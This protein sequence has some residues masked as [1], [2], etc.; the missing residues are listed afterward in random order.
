MVDEPTSAMSVLR[1]ALAQSPELGKGIV[2]SILM[3]AAV[4]IGK[5]V[6]P[7]LVQQILDRGIQDDGSWRPVFVF[8][9]GALALLIT[10]ATYALGRAT[11]LRLVRAAEDTLFGLRLAAFD[12]VHRLSVADHNDAK[13][14]LLVS[15]VTSDIETIARFAQWGG[16]AWPINVVLILGV[17]VM[18]GFYSWQLTLVAIAVYL[19]VFPILR[20]LQKRQLAA[21]E[22]FRT[23]VGETISEFSEAI[24]GA[25]VLRAY[26]V[27]GRARRRLRAAVRAQYEAD[28]GAA[29]FFSFVFSVGDVFGGLALAAVLG[30]GV[31]KGP[32]WGLEVGELIAVLFLV[33]LLQMPVSELGEILDTTQ[34]AIAGWRKVLDLIDTPVEI[35]EPENGSALESGPFAVEARSVGFAYRTGPP[36][37]IGVDT[38]I[39]AGANVAIVGQTGSGKTTFA[40][41][42]ARLADPLEGS[43][44]FA[45]V[46]L[47]ELT[48]AARHQAVRMVPQDGFLF[49]TTIA[50]NVRFGRDGATRADVDVA[51]ESLELGWWVDGLPAGLETRVGE[52]GE[53]L[54]VGE[55]QLVALARAQLADPGLLILDEATSAVDPETERALA[56]ALV[57]LAEGRTMVSIAHRL[58][59]AEVADQ[60]LVFDGGR[61][62]EQGPHTELV[63][64]GGIYTKMYASWVGNTRRDPA[65]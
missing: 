26:G 61:L 57:R 4:A 42:L 28:L 43:I 45:A 60:V 24:M 1:R 52:R 17:V 65:A 44:R 15:R 35:L 10:L 62:V 5:L 48:P 11:Y 18:L 16:V 22:V 32:G 23:R 14:G 31:W 55:R 51:F 20:A 21:Y 25:A 59:T 54:S 38:V 63:A 49:D 12:H 47:R 2:A 53:N 27:T 41:L 46:D 8:T 29:K 40:K 30:V 50:E 33:N 7:V 39:P 56:D 6:V 13:R 34:T 37:L 9:A 64:L 3:A 58:S 36:V 19:P